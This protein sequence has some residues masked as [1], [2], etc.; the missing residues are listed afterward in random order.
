MTTVILSRIESEE[1]RGNQK[2]VLSQKNSYPDDVED[3][4][5]F[6]NSWFNL[7]NEAALN[8]SNFEQ[9]VINYKLVVAAC[10]EWKRKEEAKVWREKIQMLI[11]T[12][13]RN[14]LERIRSPQELGS[15]V[16]KELFGR[17]VSL[18][19][20]QEINVSNIN[21]G[22]SARDKFNQG[23]EETSRHPTFFKPVKMLKTLN[24]AS[25]KVLIYYQQ[26]DYL[27]AI[28]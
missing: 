16:M 11:L 2:F 4:L 24:Q 25:Q 22:E 21:A 8:A 20:G 18:P 3:Y 23:S 1:P 13:K 14:I 12:T 26:E 6:V 10:M 19:S 27:S 15:L 5:I 28:K 9:L 17:E 7:L